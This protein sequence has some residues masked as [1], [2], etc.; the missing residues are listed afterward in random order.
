MTTTFFIVDAHN[1]KLILTWLLSWFKHTTQVLLWV[2]GALC[3]PVNAHDLKLYSSLVRIS[4]FFVPIT[5]ISGYNGQHGR[6]KFL[7]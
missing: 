1:L 5:N 6:L 2:S 4:V 7:L 3:L